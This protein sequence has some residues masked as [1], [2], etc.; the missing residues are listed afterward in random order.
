M[1]NEKVEIE[2]VIQKSLISA[3]MRAAL[4]KWRQMYEDRPPWKKAATI[5]DPTEIETEGYPATIA[6][7]KAR[8]ATLEMKS[9]I[10]G[11]N[12]TETENASERITFLND[13]YQSGVIEKMPTQVEFAAALGGLIIKPYLVFD[14]ES[15][16]TF[17]FDFVQADDFLPLAFSVNGKI[18]DAAFLET[19]TKVDKIYT[20]I[21]RHRLTNRGV[22]ITNTAYVRDVR[23]TNSSITQIADLGK[24]IPLTAVPEWEDLE[25]QKEIS[26]IKQLLFGYIKM[27][28]ANTIDTYSPLG[29]SVFARAADLIKQADMQYSRLLWEFR[30]GE[31]AIDVDR[32]ALIDNSYKDDDG[33]IHNRTTLGIMQQRLF[34]K[35]NI[36]ASQG[37]TYNVFNPS[38]RDVSLLNGLNNILM[39]VEDVCSLSRGTLSN[40]NAEARTA[41][42]LKINKQ[43]TYQ[44]NAEIQKAIEKALQDV[45]YAMNVYTDFYKLY[46]AEEYAVSFAWDDSVISDIQEEIKTRLILQQNGIESKLNIRMWYFGETEEQAR[47]ALEQIQEEDS[48][49]IERDKYTAYSE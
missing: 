6:R 2:D 15:N 48:G 1:A 22:M 4:T 5:E 39:R 13:S 19:K 43:R 10:T 29:I 21:E 25:P 40:V 36:D 46:P 35:T 8:M 27:P 49:G 9:V 14:N 47:A 42:E 33:V 37:E 31:L 17:E 16:G 7:E 24:L 11:V 20:R 23:S 30:G 26:G 3:K 38:F 12:G 44:S 41:T 28:E 45:V 32:N 18:T 34:R